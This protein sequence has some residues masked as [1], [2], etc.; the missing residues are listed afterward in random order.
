MG[1]ESWSTDA[2]EEQA[3]AR[4]AAGKSAFDYDATIR[5]IPSR[6]RRAHPTLDPLGVRMRESR[7]SD[8]HPESLAIAVFFDVT[9]SMGRIPMTLQEKLP[10]LNGLLVRKGLVDHPQI[11]FGGIGDIRGGVV[12][13]GDPYFMRGDRV[14][15]QVG[16]FESGN[17]MDD[18]L[19]NLYLEGGGN[20]QKREGY[21]MA[22]YFVARHTDIDCFNKRGKKG[23]MFT[24]GDEMSWGAVNKHEVKEL[25]GDQIESDIPMVEMIREVRKRYNRIHIYPEGASYDDDPDVEAHWK[26]LLGEDF[27]KLDNPEAVCELIAGVIGIREGVVD[28]DGFKTHL[29][30]LGISP[31]IVKSTSMA[32]ARMGVNLPARGS[33]NLPGIRNTNT[34]PRR[35]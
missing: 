19:G 9:G 10:E 30:Q 7:D 25:I 17:Q 16:Q 18:N 33:G 5:A 8:E 3:R 35:L 4:K 15:L 32:L 24:I 13:M 34:S 27:L 20:G 21:E 1:H 12:G 11:M 31:S 28:L 23:Y 26:G 29:R 6:L 22:D 2:Y 14:P